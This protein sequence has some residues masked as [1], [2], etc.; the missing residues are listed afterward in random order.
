M[1]YLTCIWHIFTGSN[2]LVFFFS[3]H[4]RGLLDEAFLKL[5]NENSD[6]ILYCTKLTKQ[7]LLAKANGKIP[8]DKVLEMNINSPYVFFYNENPVTAI[9]L[10]AGHC[11]GSAM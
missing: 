6:V 2:I 7:L 3:D 11:P 5:I 10:P 1:Y 4:Y 9:A 8:A